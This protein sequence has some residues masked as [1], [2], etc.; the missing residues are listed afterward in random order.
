MTTLRN[1]FKIYFCLIVVFFLITL[2]FSANLWTIS[3][4]ADDSDS[5]HANSDFISEKKLDQNHGLSQLF[6]NIPLKQKGFPM[7][8]FI[9]SVIFP[10]LLIKYYQSIAIDSIRSPPQ[11]QFSYN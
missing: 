3:N 2:I 8:R 7:L 11:R 9:L 1:K 10:I 6:L 5:A 4:P